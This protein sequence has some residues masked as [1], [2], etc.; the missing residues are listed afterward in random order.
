M[1][2]NMYNYFSKHLILV[3]TIL[4]VSLF[5]LVSAMIHPSQK[6]AGF[7]SIIENRHAP[8]LHIGYEYSGRAMQTIKKEALQ[9]ARFLGNIAPQLWTKLVMSH[10]DRIELN[11][12]AGKDNEQSH[13]YNYAEEN[14]YR[15][16]VEYRSVEISVIANGKVMSSKSAD[17]KLTAEQRTILNAADP[18]TNINVRIQFNYKKDLNEHLDKPIAGSFVVTVVPEKEAEFPGGYMKM[19]D[20]I[21]KAVTI[22]IP[23]M[24]FY[25]AKQQAIAQFT[26]NKEG[27]VVD[28]KIVKTSR[29]PKT[30]ELLLK[31][32][33][34]MP[35]WKAAENAQGIK[36]EQEFFIPFGGEGC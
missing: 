25:V 29:D 30:D 27:R 31:A 5:T 2:P 34:A 16:V 1:K 4:F 9:D 33:K 10:N 28:T 14:N 17:D 35:K 26:V 15:N 6:P 32:I 18:G 3:L 19:Q 12:Q 23:E 24:V 8:Y 11:H 36:V 20:Y 13:T 22:K 7:E 21:T